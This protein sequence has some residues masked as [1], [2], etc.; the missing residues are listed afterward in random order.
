MTNL[1]FEAAKQLKQRLENIQVLRYDAGDAHI[2]FRFDEDS[3]YAGL[4]LESDWRA[5]DDV[6]T[7][8]TRHDLEYFEIEDN[9]F[10]FTA[11]VDIWVFKD[12]DLAIGDS[13]DLAILEAFVNA[14]NGQFKS[15]LN[16]TGKVHDRIF[17]TVS[18][19][20][21]CRAVEQRYTGE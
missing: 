5:W 14:C 12:K 1:T 11:M 16:T 21:F 9:L 15:L 4:Y 8:A 6:L 13:D 7:S 19:E 20:T 2:I 17:E 3:V 18:E 10:S